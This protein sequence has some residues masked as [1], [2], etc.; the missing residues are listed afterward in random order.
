[1]KSLPCD[2]SKLTVSGL[3]L[4]SENYKDA[5]DLL[6]QCYGNTQVLINAF[7]KK[8]VQ[9]P[10]VQNSNNVECLRLFYYHVETSVRNLKTLGVE[11]NTYGSLLILLL[12]KRPPDDLRLRIA[13]KN[14]Q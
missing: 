1:M 3:S 8:S 10:A 2:S 11:I 9:L 13:Q 5:T 14:W 6:K 12:T 4:S 7:M